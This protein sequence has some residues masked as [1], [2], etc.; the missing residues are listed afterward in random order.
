MAER[1]P[2]IPGHRLERKLGAGGMGSVYLAVDLHTGARR[3]IK[4]LPTGA[5]PE[6]RARFQREGQAQAALGGHPNVVRVHSAGEERGN[7]YLVLE[8]VEGQD[9]EE[10]LKPGP[11]QPAEAARLVAA[12][13]RGLAHAHAQG[14]LHRDL[15]PANVLIAADGTPKLADLGLARVSWE[16]RMTQTGAIVGTPS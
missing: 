14:V 10:R 15:K 7:A 9:L 5:E 6:L 12:L 11:L 8:Y 4:A 16:G 1:L 2:D 13:A 3:A